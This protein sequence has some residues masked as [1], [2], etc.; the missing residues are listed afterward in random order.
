MLH[1]ENWGFIQGHGQDLKSDLSPNPTMWILNI[2][3]KCL[4]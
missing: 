3:Q 2:L 4:Y 1:I